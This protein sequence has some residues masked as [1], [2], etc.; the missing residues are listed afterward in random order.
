MVCLYEV[1]ETREN[2][3]IRKMGGGCGSSKRKEEWV[4]VTPTLVKGSTQREVCNSSILPS[5]SSTT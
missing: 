4:F 3:I 2:N 5:I 1:Y